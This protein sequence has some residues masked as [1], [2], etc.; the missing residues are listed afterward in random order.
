MKSEVA[1]VVSVSFLVA[2]SNVRAGAEFINY[3]NA[4]YVNALALVGDSVLWAGTT[5][6]VRGL[7]VGADGL[8][9]LH[10]DSAEGVSVNGRSLW[11]VHLPAPPVRWGAA[12]TANECVVT[13]SDG[14]VV[15][16]AEN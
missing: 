14:L 8:V 12:L 16:L 9:V 1:V 15:C 7:A 10:D 6:D 3:T 13:L 4:D 2:I 11:S 5:P